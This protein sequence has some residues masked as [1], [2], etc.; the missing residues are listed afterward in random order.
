MYIP[1]CIR[2]DKSPQKC[3]VVKTVAKARVILVGVGN[4]ASSLVQALRYYS[5]HATD[6]ASGVN[7]ETIGGLRINDIEIVSCFD[8]VEGKVGKDLAEAIFAEPNIAPR[9]IE[10][11]KPLGIKVKKG[12]VK[13]GISPLLAETVQISSNPEVDLVKEF[14]EVDADMVISLLPSG[15]KEA[16]Y[17]YADAAIKADLA[18]I[19][20]APTRICS[21]DK[22]VRKFKKA[23]L[24]VVGDDLQ[25][26]LGGTRLHKGI[27]EILNSFGAHI[28]NTYQLDVSGGSEGMNTLYTERRME[29]RQI[30]TDSIKRTLP[31]LTDNDIA[32]GT[33][34]YLDFLG[35]ERT[36]YFWI[37]GNYFLNTPFK[38]DITVKTTDG[39]NA[40]GT[41]VNVIRATKL[42]LNRGIDGPLLSV[43]AYGFKYPPVHVG[44]QDAVKRFEE[45]ITGDRAD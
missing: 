8:V 14:K 25:S 42:A 11:N 34:D 45:F 10:Y 9:I 17:V 30:K 18:F 41:L 22:W 7:Y 23:N 21:D 39:P 31:Y 27:L 26:Q 35:N 2:C 6:G 3:R 37:Y 19:E 12:P 36:G 13:D 20:A 38:I 4:A 16:T 29:K 44:E 43:S 1:N 33:T 32:S 15:A 5:V 40:A 24:P 28:K